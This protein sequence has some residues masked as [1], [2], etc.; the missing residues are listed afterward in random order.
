MCFLSLGV[1]RVKVPEGLHE[2]GIW[3]FLHHGLARDG[4]LFRRCHFVPHGCV[5]SGEATEEGE[6]TPGPWQ[7]L[8]W[9]VCQRRS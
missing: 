2:L 8:R 6:T 7:R 9:Y 4:F 1:Y 5:Q 3:I